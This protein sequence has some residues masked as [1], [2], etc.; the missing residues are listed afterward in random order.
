MGSLKT[1]SFHVRASQEQ[2]ARWNRAAEAEG[3]ASVGSWLALAADAYLKARARAG[4]PLRL[5]WSKGQVRVD[6]EDGST[7]DLKG[8]RSRPFGFYRGDLTGPGRRGRHAYTLVYLPD[9]RPLATF[10]Y[11]GHCKSLA[12]ELAGPLIRGMPFPDPG[13]IV[14]R[15]KR[16]ES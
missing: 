10:R 16:G 2:S 14:E 6:L 9:R 15:H 11:A 4:L 1:T 8:W 3:C 5:V 13:G 7:V 12:A